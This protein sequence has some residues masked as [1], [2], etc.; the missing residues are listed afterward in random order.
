MHIMMCTGSANYRRQTNAIRTAMH[1]Y[2][3]GRAISTEA[4]TGGGLELKDLLRPTGRCPLP[5]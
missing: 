5:R 4:E 3:E 1:R 2:S